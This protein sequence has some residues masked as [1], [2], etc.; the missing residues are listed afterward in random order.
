MR[1]A[2]RQWAPVWVVVDGSDD[3]TAEG[4]QRMAAQDP[5]LKVI[6]LPENRGKGSAVLAE[7]REEAGNDPDI[8]LLELPA[9]SPVEINALQRASTIV[10]QKSLRESGL[11]DCSSANIAHTA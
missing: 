3:G 1:D 8:H 7:V 9:A 4:L 10:I 2:R 11:V 6:V 5:D